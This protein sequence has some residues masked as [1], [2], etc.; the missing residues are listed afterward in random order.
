M[1]KKNWKWQSLTICS[2]LLKNST[3]LQDP[4]PF[5]GLDNQKSIISQ[6]ICKKKFQNNILNG[7]FNIY[8]HTVECAPGT[9]SDNG[10]EPCLPC[11]QGTYQPNSG[12][13]TCLPC[14]GQESTHGTGASSQAYCGG[15]K[16]FYLSL[17]LLWAT[18]VIGVLNDR[19]RSFIMFL[20]ICIYAHIV[21]LKYF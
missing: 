10:V 2:Q 15:M 11:P 12:Q 17:L 14:P 20:Y 9:Y 18:L 16:M 3:I 8:F 5:E 13:T 7:Y 1:W 6:L 21:I 4:L 19:I